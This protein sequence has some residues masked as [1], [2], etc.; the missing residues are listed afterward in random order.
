MSCFVFRRLT[1]VRQRQEYSGSEES[2]SCPTEDSVA[3]FED[4]AINVANHFC[5]GEVLRINIKFCDIITHVNLT[6][7]TSTNI[8]VLDMSSVI[9]LQ[10][11]V[12]KLC[13]PQKTRINRNHLE[14]D[15]RRVHWSSLQ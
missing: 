7:N 3:L 13:Q 1:R 6:V 10:A 5:I 11:E 2:S 15:G 9:M 12:I 14:D 4:Y 8:F